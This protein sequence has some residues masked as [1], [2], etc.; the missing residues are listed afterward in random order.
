MGVQAIAPGPS[1]R[2]T[3]MTLASSTTVENLKAAFAG[4]S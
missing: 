2:K 1:T 4:V 3:P